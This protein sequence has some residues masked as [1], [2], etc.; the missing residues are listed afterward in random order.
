M[1]P[2]KSKLSSL[3]QNVNARVAK[4]LMWVNKQ[5]HML[6]HPALIWMPHRPRKLSFGQIQRQLEIESDCKRLEDRNN[7]KEFFPK[8]KIEDQ[9]NQN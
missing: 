5:S 7:L 8:K 1:N 3:A 6:Y 2:L 9:I 4:I